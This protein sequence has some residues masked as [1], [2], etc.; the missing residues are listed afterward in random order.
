MKVLQTD[1]LGDHNLGIFTRASDKVCLVGSVASDGRIAQ[2]EK[3]L[4]VDVVRAS[5]GNSEIVGIFSAMNSN[6]IV[7]PRMA[8]ES[9][10]RGIEEAVKEL[11]VSVA[12]VSSKFTAL[13]NLILC[14]D[15]GAVL[16]RLL[17]AKDKR[18]IEDC[19]G[20]EAEYGT[21]AGL[22]SVGSCGIATNKG[23]VL[24]RDA[25]EEEMDGFQD[26]LKVDTDVGTANFGSP[27]IGSCAAANGN[28]VVLGES[29]TG[30]EVARIME[31]L[32]LL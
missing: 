26:V 14:N 8:G 18:E 9:E 10:V 29:T 13:G 2:M 31:T 28:G 27:F 22:A 12:V 16:S 24:H 11:G 20:V 3:V 15:R 4:K 17:S 1:F 30:P 5:V 23:C 19:L 6:G 21:V 7:L 25:S 32:S